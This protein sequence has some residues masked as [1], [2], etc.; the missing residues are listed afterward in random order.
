MLKSARSSIEELRM[1]EVDHVDRSVND[2]DTHQLEEAH[3]AASEQAAAL[4]RKAGKVR[5]AGTASCA[6]P[7]RMFPFCSHQGPEQGSHNLPETTAAQV[8]SGGAG[9][10]RTHDR[11]IMSPL[12]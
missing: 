4:P 3:V 1:R 8:R 11:Q 6:K 10:A 5:K 9:G 12:L 7:A 2:R